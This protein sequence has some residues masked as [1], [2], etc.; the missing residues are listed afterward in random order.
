MTEP[1][2]STEGPTVARAIAFARERLAE[3]EN[4]C[5]G[6]SPDGYGEAAAAATA[7]RQL[8]AILDPGGWCP[9]HFYSGQATMVRGEAR[10]TCEVCGDAFIGAWDQ[11]GERDRPADALKPCDQCEGTG[12]SGGVP[13]A[14]PDENAPTGRLCPKCG[15]SA[16]SP[17][18]EVKAQEVAERTSAS[19]ARAREAGFVTP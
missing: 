14:R 16:S 3:A 6:M 11:G 8:L 7:F 13:W 18:D 19:A 10:L 17:P 1:S 12:W 9:P 4:P 2:Q 15:G 5:E